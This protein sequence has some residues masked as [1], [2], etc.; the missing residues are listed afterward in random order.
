M[1]KVLFALFILLPTT[2]SFAEETTATGKI[3]EVGRDTKTGIKKGARAVQDETCEM[4]NGKMECMGKKLKH[5]AQNAID[6][7]K[8]KSEAGK[9]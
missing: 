2:S 3:K 7:I 5:K 4:I 6:D 8:D 1:L 9:K